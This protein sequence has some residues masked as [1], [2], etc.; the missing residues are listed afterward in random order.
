[1]R[2]F[3]KRLDIGV[4]K[5]ALFWFNPKIKSH[6][7]SGF[8]TVTPET[9]RQQ[10]KPKALLST[11][12]ARKTKSLFFANISRVSVAKREASNLFSI[13]SIF[14]YLL[15]N[16][17]IWHHNTRTNFQSAFLEAS[18]SIVSV[19]I[20]T[21]FPTLVLIQNELVQNF[22]SY[23]PLLLIDKILEGEISYFEYTNFKIYE[24]PE[25]EIR[26]FEF[27]NIK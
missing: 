21:K 20:Q 14:P 25:E 19:D 7:Y 10:N 6:S 24:R 18:C 15:Q 1:M 26:H 11:V 9:S 8:T 17:Y 5:I 2:I 16:L 12:L 22:V 23:S 3:E 27:T 4:T 13:C